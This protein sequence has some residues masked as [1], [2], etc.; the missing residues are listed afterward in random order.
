MAA[1]S[2]FR[3]WPI[4]WIEHKEKIRKLVLPNGEEVY[5][6]Y[7]VFEDTGERLPATGGKVRPCKKCGKVFPLGEGEVDPCLGV[8]PGVDN[9]CC[10]HGI[11]KASYIRFT[12]GMIIQGFTDMGKGLSP[13][14][15][16]DPEDRLTLL[17]TP[18]KPQPPK[19]RLLRENEVPRRNDY[20]STKE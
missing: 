6:G 1:K 14:M 3:G 10:G 9:A 11:S 19:G 20:Q 5:E 4:V 18:S 16:G 15:S 2:Y 17:R 13:T 12:N 8:L 7:W